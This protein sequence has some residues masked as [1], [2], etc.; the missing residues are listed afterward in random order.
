M[1]SGPFFWVY[2]I[3]SEGEPGRFYTGFTEDLDRRLLEHNNWKLPNTARYA[4]WRLKAAVGFTDR[5]RA[6]AFERYLKTASGRAFA[7]NRL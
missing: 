6:L 7:R 2:I 3:Q 4:P 1:D 5:D